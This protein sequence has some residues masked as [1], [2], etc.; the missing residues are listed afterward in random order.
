M[1]PPGK[2]TGGMAQ[3]CE[4]TAPQSSPLL[5]SILYRDNRK[6][7]ALLNKFSQTT[8]YTEV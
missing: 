5:L 6:N 2:A 7:A 3:N 4:V 8:K 1:G